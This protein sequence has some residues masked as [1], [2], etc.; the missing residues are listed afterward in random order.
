[1]TSRLNVCICCNISCASFQWVIAAWRGGSADRCA[2]RCGS[3]AFARANS[4][5]PPR[6]WTRSSTPQRNCWPPTRG[7]GGAGTPG[8]TDRAQP[9]PLRDGS[10]G[11]GARGAAGADQFQRRTGCA[12][13]VQPRALPNPLRAPQ[14]ALWAA[15]LLSLARDLV[16]EPP[17]RRE[18]RAIKRRP[19][20]PFLTRPRQQGAVVGAGV[21]AAAITVMQQARLG[22]PVARGP[23]AARPGRGP[24]S[25]RG[26]RPSRR[27]AG[28]R[29]PA[30]RPERASLRPSGYT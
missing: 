23:S 4:R 13:A 20:Y 30:P 27:R 21:L 22:S 14:K 10:S 2:R 3:G 29:D 5:W 9:A 6:C 28:C 12:A 19:K 26:Q 25:A 7:A 8:R 15:L 24:S 18:P 16:P 11:A 1:M 17:G